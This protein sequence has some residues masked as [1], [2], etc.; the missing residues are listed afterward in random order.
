VLTPLLTKLG[1]VE[2]TVRKVSYQYGTPVQLQ[3]AEVPL[4]SHAVNAV[5]RNFVFRKFGPT[6]PEN[7][8]TVDWYLLPNVTF[9]AVMI[10]GKS[11]VK[12]SYTLK[13]GELGRS[14]RFDNFLKVVKSKPPRFDNFLKVVKSNRRRDLTTFKKLS[15]LTAD[16]STNL[17]LLFI[18][19]IIL[20][21]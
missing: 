18:H 16:K 17:K 20:L 1:V 7:E 21:I 19:D 2:L 6:V 15:N 5:K 3:V 13:D 10:G 12:A 8:E 9:E 11:V 14:P 4:Y